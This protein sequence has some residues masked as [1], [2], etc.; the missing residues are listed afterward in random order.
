MTNKQDNYNIR[1]TFYVNEDL[2]KNFLMNRAINGESMT[3][4]IVNSLYR[5]NRRR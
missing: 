3:S 4:T 5:L 2:E 1:K